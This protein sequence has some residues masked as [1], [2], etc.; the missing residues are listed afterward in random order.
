[1]LIRTFVVLISNLRNKIRCPRPECSSSLMVLRP[2]FLTY[3]SSRMV[4]NRLALQTA[5]FSGQTFFRNVST[6]KNVSKSIFLGGKGLSK[7]CEYL[8]SFC[9]YL[10]STLRNNTPF[11]QIL[12]TSHRPD[13]RLIN[14]SHPISVFPLQILT[15]LL[16]CRSSCSLDTGGPRTPP[17]PDNYPVPSDHRGTVDHQQKRKSSRLDLRVRIF[18][19]EDTGGA[20]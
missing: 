6:R 5:F 18:R 15:W 11:W 20:G 17:N 3:G 8:H 16:G 4:L 13:P 10:Y 1:M 19:Q 9:E 7:R 14:F 2:W 12:A